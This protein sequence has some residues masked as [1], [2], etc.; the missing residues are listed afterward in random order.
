MLGSGQETLDFLQFGL[1]STVLLLRI[2][3]CVSELTLSGPYLEALLL[4]NLFET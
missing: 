4:V 2:S 1:A 3:L